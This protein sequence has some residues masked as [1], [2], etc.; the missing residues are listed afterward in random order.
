MSVRGRLLML[1]DAPYIVEILTPRRGKVGT[2]KQGMERFA[3]RYEQ[4][5]TSGC[6][7]SIPDNPMGKL[8]YSALETFEYLG[9]K[10]DSEKTLINLNTFHSKA[11]LDGILETAASEGLR[12]L[13]VVRGDGGPD[14]PKLQPGDLGVHVKM[15]TSIELLWYI[16]NHYAGTFSTGAAF[17]QYKPESVER[18][19]LEK[20]KSSGAKF[21][22][23]QPVM[24][25][26]PVVAEILQDNIPVVLE[27]WMSERIELF[28]KSVKSN[29]SMD[30]EHF[31]PME[32][33][34]QLHRLYPDCCVYLSMLH[35]LPDWRERLP[36]L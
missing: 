35:S 12:Y 11:E 32:N 26:D 4:A 27:A 20:K 7:V 29:S 23:L 34:D 1:W 5:V 19:K 30:I 18:A 9:L 33:L 36:R 14:L 31:D 6:A 28:V 16:N 21:I 22:V 8:R 13:L 3:Q 2:E 15:V 25:H 10:A 17:N 24:G